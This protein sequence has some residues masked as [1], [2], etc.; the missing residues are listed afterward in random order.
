M[1]V[2]TGNFI[3]DDID[4]DVTIFNQ[5]NETDVGAWPQAKKG[6]QSTQGDIKHKLSN[7]IYLYTLLLEI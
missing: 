4:F 2:I 6:P 7:I 5:T 1:L 3:S